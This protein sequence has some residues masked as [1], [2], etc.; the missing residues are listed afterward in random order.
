MTIYGRHK[1]KDDSIEDLCYQE[2]NGSTIT[3][4]YVHLVDT[5]GDDSSRSLNV[6]VIW[7]QHNVQYSEEGEP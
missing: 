4:V 6:S 3:I 2:T 1:D 7:F 5:F